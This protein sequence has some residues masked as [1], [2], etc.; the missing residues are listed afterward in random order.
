M[1]GLEDLKITIY[2]FIYIGISAMI[3]WKSIGVS[4]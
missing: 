1:F 4:E 3:V 2:I